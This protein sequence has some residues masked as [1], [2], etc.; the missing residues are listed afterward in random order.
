[1]NHGAECKSRNTLLFVKLYPMTL[2]IFIAHTDIAHTDLDGTLVDSEGLCNQ[3]FL[4][5]LPQLHD[6]LQT[7]TERYRGQK[8]S[9]ILIDLEN[10]LGL[11]LPES[12]EQCFASVLWNSSR[13]I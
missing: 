3:A 9:S 1:M 12:F 2:D 6:P 10:R 5:L 13:V 8:L 4:D 7:L 11:N